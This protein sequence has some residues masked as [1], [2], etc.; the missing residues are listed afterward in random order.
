[1]NESQK[2]AL[3]WENSSQYF[4]QMKYYDWMLNIIPEHKTVLEVGCGTGYSTLALANAGFRVIAIEKNPDCLIKAKE[5][6]KKQCIHPENVEFICGDIVDGSVQT[7]L[8]VNH[9]FDIVLCWN[10]GSYWDKKMFAHYVPHMIEYGLTEQDIL[11]NPESSY[12]EVI[13]WTSC[14]L[15]RHKEASVHII[16][17]S[18]KAL[19]QQNDEYYYVLQRELGFSNIKYDN[20][21]A[22]TLSGIGRMLT[23]D[24]I[25]NQADKIDIVFISILMT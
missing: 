20:L 18:S 8:I 21:N 22:T 17:R 14:A 4:Y 9:D 19:N 23:V 24:G 12:S 3:Q 11:S 1:M 7:E 2:Y 13:I 16:D 10:I 25:P 15:A 5:L 6:I